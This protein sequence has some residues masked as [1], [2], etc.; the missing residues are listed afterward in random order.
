MFVL[1]VKLNYLT[2]Q[3]NII[4]IEFAHIKTTMKV[5]IFLILSCRENQGNLKNN[6]LIL[7]AIIILK[8]LSF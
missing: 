4:I 1:Y 3:N 8:S 7:L 2:N 6:R 5:G